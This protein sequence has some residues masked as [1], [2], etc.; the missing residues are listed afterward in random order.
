[1][2]GSSRRTQVG[3]RGELGREADPAAFAA[4]QPGDPS[5]LGLLG[6]EAESLEHLVDPGVELVAA[7]VGERS[8]VT[9]VLLEGG[10]GDLLSQFGELAACSA[11]DTSSAMT[12]RT[13][14]PPHPTRSPRRRSRDAG[15]AAKL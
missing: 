7:Q 11:S 4:A 3:R 5:R 12:A 9:A 8:D 13:A 15:R 6:V 14:A 2:V 10:L 1:M